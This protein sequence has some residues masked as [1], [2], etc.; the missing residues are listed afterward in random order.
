MTWW[1]RFKKWLNIDHIVDLAVDLALILFDV[2][3]S[4]ILIVMRLL[5]WSIGKYMLDGVKNK[6]KKL[7]HWLQTKPWW[8]SVIVAPIALIVTFYTLV[9]LWL[10]S[11]VFDPQLWTE[12]ELPSDDVIIQEHLKNIDNSE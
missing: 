11:A 3:T 2:I 4:P 5:R 12:D 10:A 8:V 7:I 1:E 6:I 9:A